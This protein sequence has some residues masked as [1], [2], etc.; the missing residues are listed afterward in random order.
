MSIPK[1]LDHNIAR[2]GGK[3]ALTPNF[4]SSKTG[5]S[6]SSKSK[7]DK[8]KNKHQYNAQL[9]E[10]LGLDNSMDD[11]SGSG[12]VRQELGSEDG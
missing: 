4:Y 12:S 7:S 11:E 8:T 2:E 6:K 10:E 9:L 5:N 3:G 1:D